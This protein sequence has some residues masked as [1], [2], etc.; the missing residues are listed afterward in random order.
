MRGGRLTGTPNVG[1]AL[2]DGGAR[3]WRLASAVQDD[4]GFEVNL[5]ALRREPANDVGPVDHG[6]MLRSLIR[7]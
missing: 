1:F 4:L 6:V 5:E 2:S 7:W 3:D